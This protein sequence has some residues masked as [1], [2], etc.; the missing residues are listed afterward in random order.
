[1]RLFAKLKASWIRLT[2]PDTDEQDLAWRGFV[3]NNLIAS[4]IIL[5][6]VLFALVFGFWLLGFDDG[7]ALV[8]IFISFFIYLGIYFI[9]RRHSIQWA[10][11]AFSVYAIAISYLLSFGWGV[12]DITNSAM[13]AGAIVM[14]SM[15]LRGRALW[16]AIGALLFGYVAITGAELNGWFS[17]PFHTELGANRLTVAVFLL[18]L[19]VLGFITAT[20]IDRVLAAQVAEAAR[21]Q[22]LE[23]RT[24][25][26]A[27]LQLS[28]LPA[29]APFHPHFEIDGCSCPARD[30]GGDFYSYHVVNKDE[31]IIIIGDV[32]GKGISAALLMAVTTGIIESL[33]PNTIGPGELLTKIAAQI[34]KHCHRSQLN[35]ACLAAFLQKDRLRVA[36][37]GCI[38]PL[39]RRPDGRVE[40]LQASGLPIG[41]GLNQ[42]RYEQ[43]EIELGPN[44]MIIFS[45]DGVVETQNEAN[46]IFGFEA[47]EQITTAGPV[48]RAE[49]MVNHIIGVTR[50]F[51]GRGEQRDD[52]T[53]VVVRVKEDAV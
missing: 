21:R 37:A 20:L 5:S 34:E 43:S 41:T 28:M 27:E 33:V 7:A 39:I 51:Q 40:W 14:T 32:T 2:E 17:P 8:A 25:I 29:V 52:T 23:S 31:L 18:Y 44:D 19:S 36:N 10:I 47:L 45:T 3:L 11:R 53:L 15:L 46:Q 42:T 26:A 6:I 24:Q 13:Y 48:D 50:L 35:A 22:E 1:M 30:V 38:E 49:A 9:S 12:A 16:L 4:L